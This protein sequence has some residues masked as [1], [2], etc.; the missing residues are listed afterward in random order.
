[1]RQF[2]AVVAAAFA[3]PA[4]KTKSQWDSPHVIQAPLRVK[5]CCGGYLKLG[6]FKVRCRP[7]VRL[8]QTL[9]I[10]ASSMEASFYLRGD[11]REDAFDFCKVHGLDQVMV[12]SR[13][14]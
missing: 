3:M 5:Q 10:Q 14:P 12:E 7:D 9:V 1:L 11:I 4:T 13:L 2:L 8:R 6:A